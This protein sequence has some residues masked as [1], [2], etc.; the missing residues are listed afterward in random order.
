[1]SLQ[2]PFIETFERIHSILVK[3]RNQALQAVNAQMVLAYWE[4]GREIVAE[5]QRVSN[6]LTLEKACSRIYRNS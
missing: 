3:A 2:Q 6:G 5:E 4:I 1:M